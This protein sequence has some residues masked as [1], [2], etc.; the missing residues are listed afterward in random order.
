[1]TAVAIGFPDPGTIGD[2]Y[3]DFGSG[4][5][6]KLRAWIV[7][8]DG[9]NVGAAAAM[10]RHKMLAPVENA[11]AGS[12]RI[13]WWT[14]FVTV[15]ATDMVP[16][17]LCEGEKCAKTKTPSNPCCPPHNP[18]FPPLESLWISWKFRMDVAPQDL[19]CLCVL[20]S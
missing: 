6:A 16:S 7:A 18:R 13:E 10:L 1:M 4:C 9:R 2:G 3:G 17:L 5:D 19:L 20:G 11:A 8:S 15:R 12:A 14:Y